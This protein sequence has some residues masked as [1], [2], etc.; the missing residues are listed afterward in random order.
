MNH[1]LLEPCQRRHRIEVRTPEG[2]RLDFF[3]CYF[4]LAVAGTGQL[5][6][7]ARDPLP[8]S[9]Q[10]LDYPFTR[11]EVGPAPGFPDVL[12]Q[13]KHGFKQQIFSTAGNYALE[14][15][16]DLR[17][18]PGNCPG[19]CSILSN[20]DRRPFFGAESQKAVKVG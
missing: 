17:E 10:L 6:G 4:V 9:A 20:L 12:L 15:T 3:H 18:T 16:K 1:H 8:K 11:P 19:S 14:L 13:T 2:K 7:F 5:P